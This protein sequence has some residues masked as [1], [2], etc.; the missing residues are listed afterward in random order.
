MRKLPAAP[1]GVGAAWGAKTVIRYRRLHRLSAILLGLYLAVHLANHLAGLAGQGAHIAFMQ[2]ARVVYRHPLVE[3]LLLALFLWQAISGSVLIAR[4]WKAR[5][6]LIA[7][8]QIGSGGYLLFFLLNHVGAVMA[9]RALFGLD[10]DF[11]FAAAGF[12]IGAFGLF[13][14][15]YY[16]L[17]VAAL[18]T[19]L[20]CAMF[21]V[22]DSR[23]RAVRWTVLLGLALTGTV[24]GLLFVL[25]MMGAFH[26]VDI[27]AAYRAP[28]G[29]A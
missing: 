22:L 6:G 2:A 9:G 19:H 5:D 29:S 25:M 18:F 13:F 27:P 28:Y 7:W 14:A 23:P 26:P 15:P 17:A 4:R 24:L 11:R 20:G 16:L 12:H 21:F 1:E 8:L 10:T 3:G